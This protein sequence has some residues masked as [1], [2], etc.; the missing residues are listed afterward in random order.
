MILDIAP[1]AERI[2]RLAKSD[3]RAALDACQDAAERLACAGPHLLP[4]LH[5]QTGR[6]FLAVGK[7][8][9]AARMFTLARAAETEHGLTVDEERLEAV[10]LE[11]TLGGALTAKALS[12]YA[13]ELT[14]RVPAAEALERFTRLCV[15]RTAGGLAPSRPLGSALRALARAAGRHPGRAEQDYLAALLP[16][17]PAAAAEV[18]NS[19][20]T[21]SPS[22]Y[23]R[24]ASPCT[25]SR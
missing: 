17:D 15:R 8:T 18:W 3:A 11:L 22:P 9:Y 21:P 1:E 20:R 14:A 10:C 6:V 5:E 23:E 2:A 16:R 24:E 12:A 7:P 19:P 13:R 25:E 4:T